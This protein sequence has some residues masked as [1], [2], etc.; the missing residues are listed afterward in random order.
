[1]V[2]LISN[3]VNSLNGVLY[4]YILIGLL[5][6]AGIH[7]SIKLK[8]A[9]FTMIKD[10]VKL[11][12]SNEG[13]DSSKGLSSFQA[14]CIST[15]SRVGTGNMAGVAI[16]IIM[17]GPGAIFWMWM[18]ALIGASSSII[19]SILAQVYKVEDGEGGFVG[20][21]AYYIE[22]GLKSRWAAVAFAVSTIGFTG[23]MVQSVLSNSI[24][25]AFEEA[26]GLNPV[27]TTL[28]IVA[29]SAFVVFGSVKRL[30][31]ICEKIVPFMAVIYIG[32]AVFVIVKNIAILPATIGLIVGSAFGGEQVIGGMAGAALMNGVKRGLFS[33]EAGM[34]TA[35]NAAAA[36]V[37]THPVK[38]A[39]VQAL[40]VFIDTLFICGATAFMILLAGDL[41]TNPDLG[42]TLV[43]VAMAQHVGG[44]GRIFV[45]VCIMFFSFSTIMGNYYYSQANLTY[46]TKD[47][48]AHLALKIGVM[49]MIAVGGI[50]ETTLVWDMG[51]LFMGVMTLIN[52]ASIFLLSKTAFAVFTDYKNQKAKG[53]DP[54]FIANNIEGLTDVECWGGTPNSVE[55]EPETI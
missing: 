10:M 16:A 35:P 29:A 53:V 40:G 17:G 12:T 50:A 23:F 13:N 1:M 37:T 14:F 36:A 28:F 33:N 27:I 8:F 6:V 49:T 51:D 45:S 31:K 3:V 11:I 43:Q 38:Q 48:R 18:I 55:V 19:E 24:T 39:L 54:V 25:A 34:G 44:I 52:V 42:V 30:A 22:K 7:F 47:K 46:M 5:L 21:P 41:Y 20:G 26:Y 32:V 15:A 4:G 2:D 9:Q